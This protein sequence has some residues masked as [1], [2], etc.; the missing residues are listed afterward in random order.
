MIK[1]CWIA[2]YTHR[3]GLDV[4]PIFSPEAP[5][6]EDLIKELDNWE[7]DNRDDEF[8]EIAGPFEVPND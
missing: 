8:F 5:I 2:I 1:K 7:G 4:W 6:I 3:H